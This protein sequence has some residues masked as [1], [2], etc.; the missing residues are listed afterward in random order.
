MCERTR[1]V[2]QFVSMHMQQRA[3]HTHTRFEWDM[4]TRHVH[5]IRTSV[6][7]CVSMLTPDTAAS[8]ERVCD[9][10]I[11]SNDYVRCKWSMAAIKEQNEPNDRYP[12]GPP[13]IRIQ[14]AADSLPAVVAV[15]AGSRLLLCPHR[16]RVERHAISLCRRQARR[17]VT[18]NL[19]RSLLIHK[20]H[21]PALVHPIHRVLEP[22]AIAAAATHK[23]TDRAGGT[24]AAVQHH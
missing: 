18:L 19:I 6:R 13:V 9:G 5:T 14:Y 12:D 21:V 4:M 10:L 7:A 1:A 17:H 16:Q 23:W 11:N 15:V 3:T 2:V 8:V 24:S 22:A 20:A